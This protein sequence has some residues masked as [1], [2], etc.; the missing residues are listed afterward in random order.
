MS[1]PAVHHIIADQFLRNQLMVKFGD[2]KSSVFWKEMNAGDF[3]PAYHLGAQGPDFLFFNMNDW[4]LGA[5]NKPVAKAYYEVEEFMEEFIQQLKALI[6]EGVWVLISTL[7][8]MAEDAVERSALLSEISQLLGDVQNNIDTLKKI[9]ETKIED[10][11]MNAH[12]W[13]DILKHPQQHGQPYGEWWWFDTMHIR[14]TGQ[15][16][17]ELFVNSKE[18]SMERA[19]ALGYLTHYTTDVVGHSFVNAVSGGPYR[20]HGQ[21][22]KVVE[23]H[24]DVWAYNK[25]AGGELVK[26]KLGEQYLFHGKDELPPALMEFILKCIRNT[27]YDKSG[28]L[29]GK[30]ING[31]DLTI[32]YK[33]WLRWFRSAT[34]SLDLPVPTPYSL[35]AEIKEAW[36]K[37]TTNVG[38]IGNYV[39]G[40][41][42]GNGGI[43][44]FFKALAALIAGPILLAAALVDFIAGS[45]TTLGAAPIRYLLSLSY[46][47]L[48]NAFMNFR[49]GLALTG[50]AFPTVNGL[51]HFMSKH[52]INTGSNDI[53]NHNANSLPTKNAYPA[54]K[55]KMAGMEAESHLIYP[56]PTAANLE[57]DMSVGFP[58]SYFN[59][60]PEWYMTHPRNTFNRGLYDYF[61]NFDESKAVGPSTA[62]VIANYNSFKSMVKENGLGN[63]VVF[64]M[65]LYN[66]FVGSGDKVEYPNFCLD[67]DRGHAFKCWRKV[68]DPSLINDPVNDP[69]KTNVAIEQDKEVP[70]VKTDIIGTAGGVL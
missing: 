35:T 62:E 17:R 43:L 68:Y 8:T 69:A 67:S 42:S 47:A 66:E 16:L 58:P 32:A 34:N 49:Q 41:L 63:A 7:E 44:G 20:T 59:N 70:N 31:D 38:D 25:Y 55:F 65:N 37:F 28:N 36:D 48:Y 11:I 1:G 3:A 12:D 54:N 50:F 52:I 15:F 19:F 24:Q 6:P 40:S 2:A 46:E 9:V 21:R 56:W 4:P 61:K 26:S 39:G 33:T 64:S 57:D 23:N 30:E 29:Y 10:Y 51:N 53:F 14:R 27:Y 22:H 18:F 60:T 45:I 13:F 5:A